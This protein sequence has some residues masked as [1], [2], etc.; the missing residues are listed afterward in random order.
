MLQHVEH[1]N[2]PSGCVYLCESGRAHCVH[3]TINTQIFLL[4]LILRSS[5]L[6][7]HFLLHVLLNTVYPVGRPCVISQHSLRLSDVSPR[8]EFGLSLTVDPNVA[9]RLLSRQLYKSK[10]GTGSRPLGL[11][12]K[13]LHWGFVVQHQTPFAHLFCCVFTSAI[14]EEK[15]MLVATWCLSWR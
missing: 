8:C 13:E 4:T 12:V 11:P 14:L 3:V 2:K 5:I 9:D 1:S 6:S 7:F 10:S 15:L